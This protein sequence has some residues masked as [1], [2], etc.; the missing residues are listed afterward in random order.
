MSEAKEGMCFS[1][2]CGFCADFGEK[3]EPWVC[4]KCYEVIQNCYVTPAIKAAEDKRGKEVLEMAC[5]YLAWT[6]PLRQAFRERFGD[7]LPEGVLNG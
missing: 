4:K 3:A 2:R 7:D 6:G 5:K 1:D